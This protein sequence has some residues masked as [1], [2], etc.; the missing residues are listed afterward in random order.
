MAVMG[1][2]TVTSTTPENILLGAGTI[3]KNLKWETNKWTGEIIG[4]TSGG[5]KVSDELNCIDEVFARNHFFFNCIIKEISI[6]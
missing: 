6:V 3:H 2:H 5:N 1:K 4:A